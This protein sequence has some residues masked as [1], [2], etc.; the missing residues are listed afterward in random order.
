MRCD[1]E[2]PLRHHYDQVS[3]WQAWSGGGEGGGFEPAA[4]AA[5]LLTAAT[6]GTTDAAVP[7]PE[8]RMCCSWQRCRFRYLLDLLYNSNHL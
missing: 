5:I 3:A 7:L 6:R 8:P 2:G 1:V 4:S